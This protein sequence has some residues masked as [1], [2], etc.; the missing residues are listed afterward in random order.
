MPYTSEF[1]SYYLDGEENGTYKIRVH[2]KKGI[3]SPDNQPRPF[4]ESISME[5]RVSKKSVES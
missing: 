4:R 3:L 5:D 1:N 2:K